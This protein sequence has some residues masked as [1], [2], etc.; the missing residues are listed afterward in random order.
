MSK[1]PAASDPTIDPAA[2]P[3]VAGDGSDHATAPGAASTYERV[4]EPV[5]GFTLPSL[6]L[7]TGNADLIYFLARR[8]VAARYKQTAVGF[9]WVAIQPALMAVVFS[10]FLGGVAKVPS[11]DDVPYPVFAITG[12][13]LWVA[14]TMVLTRASISVVESI[15]LVSKVYFPRILIPTAASVAPI[16]DFVIAFMVALVVTLVYGE[17]LSPRVLLVPFAVALIVALALGAGLWA[18]ALNVRYHDVTVLVPFIV[19]VGLFVTPI[20]YPA[21]LVP[22]NFQALYALNPLVGVFE[23]YRWMLFPGAQAP[24][25]ALAYSTG[26][27][28]LLLLTG[29][30]YFQRAQAGFADYI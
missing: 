15:N 19:Q 18:S 22:S 2:A 14:F 25:L 17:P 7:F 29:A 3:A 24:G 27:A 12:L 8:D 4:I 26:M 9:L 23:A 6:R 20:I 28:T 16:V 11:G 1:M 10:L 30:A 13:T 5:R 21:K